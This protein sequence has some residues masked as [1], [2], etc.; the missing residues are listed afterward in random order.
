M[1]I[2]FSSQQETMVLSIALIQSSCLHGVPMWTCSTVSRRKVIE[3]CAKYA[4]KSEPRSQPLKEIFTTIVRSLK[5]DS[6]SLKAVQKLLINSVGERDFSAQETCHLLLQLPMFK[7]SRD[8]VV[9]SLDGSRAVD[10]HLDEDQPATVPSP[11]D[12]YVS[13]PTTALFQN[14][15][16]LQFVQD[17]SM[18][19]ES[20]SEPSKRR[21]K[22][23][24]ITRPYCPYDPNGP[25]YEQYCQQKLMLHVPFRHQSELL[26]NNAT[27]TAAYAEFLQSGNIP[28]S[29]EDDIHRLQ[30]SSQQL[31]EDDNEVSLNVFVYIYVYVLIQYSY[32]LRNKLKSSLANDQ[33]EQ[34]KSGCSS[35]RAT[36]NC[37][38]LQSLKKT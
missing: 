26:G 20:G 17:Y 22:V 25:K 5:E 6:S 3:Y 36:L 35:A 27:F 28:P 10:E 9:L 38:Q 1:K 37:S 14:M 12:H 11:L 30:Q 21:K 18:P 33:S 16:L 32:Y 8:F 23:V 31:I 19:R 4:T 13:R 24:V 34:W 2:L 29:L 15:P 7:A